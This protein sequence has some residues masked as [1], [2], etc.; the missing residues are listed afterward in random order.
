MSDKQLPQDYLS[1]AERSYGMDHQWYD[2][3]MLQQ[4]KTVTWPDN[5]KLALWLNVSV[6]YFPLDQKG[7][8]YKVPGGMT[9]PYPDLRHFSL[10]DYGN[11]VG[12]FRILAALDNFGITPTFAINSRLVEQAP[13]LVS[14]LA[15]RNNEIICHGWDMD[16]LHY[17]DAQQALANQ[18]QALIAKSLNSLREFTGQAI[19]GWLSPAK[20]QSELTPSLLKQHGIE[21]CCDWVNDDMPYQFN[22]QHGQL[23]NMPIS[24]ELDDQ[25]IL[26]SNLHSESS[27]LEQICDACDYL[28]AEAEREGGRIL[29][30]NIHPWLLGQPH[31]IGILEQALEYISSKAGIWT[32]SSSEILAF[33]KSKAT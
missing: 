11:R 28:L 29:A 9:M 20:N 4:R 33:V 10:R 13:Q 32:C 23:W 17:G 18:E 2:W 15:E 1:Y 24:T 21:Y 6:Q 3:S 27:Y 19:T 25:F 30:L 5:K 7:V 16:T 14:F 26:Q 22:T 31:R 8:P 12:I